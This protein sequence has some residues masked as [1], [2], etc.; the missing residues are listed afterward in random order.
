MSKKR[1][2]FFALPFLVF[3]LWQSG[4]KKGSLLDDEVVADIR[5][6]WTIIN[7]YNGGYTG[8]FKC[9]FSGTMDSGTVT[10]EFDVLGKYYVGRAYSYPVEFNFLSDEG[11]WTFY[12]SYIGQFTDSNYMEGWGTECSWRAIREVGTK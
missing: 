9:T 12:E 10:T 6:Q 4:C 2:V 8:E 7:Y 1:L 5:G 3:V 11:N